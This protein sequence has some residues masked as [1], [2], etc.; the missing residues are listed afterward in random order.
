MN[1]IKWML[2]AILICGMGAFTACTS[3]N[4]DNPVAPQPEKNNTSWHTIHVSMTV[5]PESQL[6]IP[7]MPKVASSWKWKRL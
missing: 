4:G 3:D 5:E 2:A 6:S 7:T 1:T